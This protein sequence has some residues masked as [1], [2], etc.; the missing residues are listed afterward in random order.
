M[1]GSPWYGVLSEYRQ[2]GLLKNERLR[3]RTV[4]MRY[5]LLGKICLSYTS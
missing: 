4:T 1:S 3:C 5:G 2:Q